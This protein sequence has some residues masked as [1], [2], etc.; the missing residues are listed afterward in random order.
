MKEELRQVIE[1]TMRISKELAKRKAWMKSL[2]LEIEKRPIIER[3]DPEP[4]MAGIILF[5]IGLFFLFIR[6]HFSSYYV[7]RGLGLPKTYFVIVFS[8]AIFCFIL[9]ILGKPKEK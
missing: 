9:G 4:I 6:W 8:L 3:M 2:I 5:L 7:P 1:Y